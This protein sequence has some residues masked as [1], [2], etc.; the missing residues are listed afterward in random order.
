MVGG[1]EPGTYRAQAVATMRNAVSL[2]GAHQFHAEMPKNCANAFV[3]DA[4]ERNA[5]RL[6]EP[7]CNLSARRASMT[8]IKL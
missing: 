2:Y 6:D 5:P 8:I 7:R 4:T 1:F 3:T